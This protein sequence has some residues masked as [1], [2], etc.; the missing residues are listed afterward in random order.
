MLVT[1]PLNFA[2]AGY[3]SSTPFPRIGFELLHAE[4]D[5]LRLRVEP[6]HLHLDLLADIERLGRVIDAPPR[7]VG[8]VQQPVD[9]AEIDEGAVIG[10][11]L[12]HAVQ[13]LA[14]LQA[15]DQLGALLGA[16]LFQNGA[17]RHDDVAARAVHLEDLERLRRAQ[18]RGDVAHRA[19]IDLAARQER[20]GAA[21]IHREAAL[22]AAEDRAGNAF[23]GLEI[24]F[25]LRPGLLAPRLFARQRGLAVLVLHAFEE[26]LD[27]VADL[28]LG[29]GAADGEFL[30]R[31]AA[32]R[33]EA[34]I[35][36]GKVVLDRDDLALDDG[37]FEPAGAGGDPERLVEQRGEILFRSRDFGG[38]CC[39]GHSF[40]SIPPPFQF[41]KG[42]ARRPAGIGARRAAGGFGRGRI[43]PALQA[44]RRRRAVREA[45]SGHFYPSLAAPGGKRTRDNLGRPA[46]IP[47]RRRA[48]S[49]QS[50]RRRGLPR[51]VRPDA[52]CRA[53]RVPSCPAGHRRI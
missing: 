38:F 2:L 31:D 27:G 43:D 37:P 32:L 8:D 50:F 21:Q 34:D 10:D 33:F 52:S 23:V 48:A 19:D 1:R 11:V 42:G 5:A 53:R 45:A 46:R 51:A 9:A 40:S 29:R 18:Q 39:D 26:D 13:D 3:F 16:A 44:V 20:D 7:D 47:D 15:G 22:D 14:F 24:L 25:E 41:R 30:E 12:H 28:D 4:R 17:A 35:D 6:D 49:Y 36:Q